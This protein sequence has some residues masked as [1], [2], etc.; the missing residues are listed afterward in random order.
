MKLTSRLISG[1]G[2]SF[3]VLADRPELSLEE[4]KHFARSICKSEPA[5]GL[6]FL[7]NKSANLYQWDFF[8][9]DG[10]DAEM[11]G[12]ASRCVGYYIKHELNPP[13]N[14]WKLETQAGAV[15]IKSLG[16]KLFQITMTPLILLKSSHGFFCN[17]GVPHLVVEVTS[18]SYYSKY[19]DKAQALRWH[20]DFQPAGTNV[21]LVSWAA[22][23]EILQ[24]VTF[25][26]GVE[27]YTEACGTGAMAAAFYNFKKNA[28]AHSQVEMPGGTL[29]MDLNNLDK[30][31]MTGP[32]VPLG[33]YKYE[34]EI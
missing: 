33:K 24:A 14:I 30:P 9:N 20:K 13:D 19:K 2:N 29:I 31:L 8:N 18:P 15:E 4:K 22:R 5:D 6:I 7:K 28:L 1:A 21:T 25:E 16:N 3:H 27:N 11:C 10:S 17:T 32:A 23:P 12:N 26:R 34:F